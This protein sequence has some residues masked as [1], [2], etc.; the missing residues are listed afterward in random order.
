MGQNQSLQFKSFEIVASRPEEQLETLLQSD[1]RFHDSSTA[2]AAYG[3]SWALTYFLL[4]TRT[5]EFAGLSEGTEYSATARAR[6]SETNAYR[7]FRKHFGEDLERLDREFVKYMSAS[8]MLARSLRER[9]PIAAGNESRMPWLCQWDE[10]L[11]I[12]CH[13]YDSGKTI[14][15]SLEFGTGIASGTQ[16]FHDSRPPTVAYGESWRSLTFLLKTR[17]KEFSGYLKELST[18]PPHRAR[19][20]ETDAYQ[21]FEN[22]SGKIWNDSTANS[23]STCRVSNVARSLRERKPANSCRE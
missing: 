22:T 8:L 12:G 11:G 13:C 15:V 19:R 3:E 7:I 9:K 10:R 1:Q 4:K 2:T 16:R 17:T 21:I 20:S 6:R 23:S 14:G 18:R 5:K